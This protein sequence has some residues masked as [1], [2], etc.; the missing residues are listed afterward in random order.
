MHNSQHEQHSAIS[1][2]D[3]TLALHLTKSIRRASPFAQAVTDV[4]LVSG[5]TL[6]LVLLTQIRLPTVPVPITGQTLGILLIGAAL[7]WQRGVLSVGCYLLA[8]FMGVPVF[9]AV[10]GPAAFVGPTG[11]FLLSFVPA[12]LLVGFL[13]ERGWDRRIGGA[14]VTF[15]AGHTIIFVVGVAWLTVL[16][17]FES[18]IQVGFIPFIP[19]MILKTAIATMLLPLAWTISGLRTDHDSIEEASR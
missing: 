1:G 8:G 13:A 2:F 4:A 6:L 7:G 5:G 17:G 18:A 14:L 15:I 3:S 16:I 10:I 9:A 12:V 19:G 11:G